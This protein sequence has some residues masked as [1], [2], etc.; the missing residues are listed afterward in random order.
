MM[1]TIKFRFWDI[2]NKRFTWVNPSVER[3]ALLQDTGY[4]QLYAPVQD[5]IISQ[6][7]GQQDKNHRDIYEGDLVRCPQCKP[8][9]VHIVQ[10]SDSA[11]EGFGSGFILDMDVP[12]KWEYLEIVGNIFENPE[13]MPTEGLI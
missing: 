10:W 13:L 5:I 7:T 1:R 11:G 8:D 12:W 3:L 4:Y 2:H 9:K 6:Y